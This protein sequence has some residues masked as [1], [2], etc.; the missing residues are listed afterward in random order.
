[1][2]LKAHTTAN[3]KNRQERVLKSK[4]SKYAWSGGTRKQVTVA[5]RKA[6]QKM[7]FF[8][9]NLKAFKTSPD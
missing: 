1:M 5:A 4:Y 8:F 6:T 2:F 3:V 9:I 7:V